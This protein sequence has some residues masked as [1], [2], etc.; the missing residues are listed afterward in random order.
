MFL[1]NDTDFSDGEIFDFLGF[2]A[3]W[4]FIGLL[5][6]R[7]AGSLTVADTLDNRQHLEYLD[8]AG[9]GQISNLN[10]GSI[11]SEAA[12]LKE[13]FVAIGGT[14]DAGGTEDPVLQGI[15]LC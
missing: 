15:D 11:L 12:R 5:D 13:W 8:I 2:S 1:P 4:K 14:R 3:H 6:C 7:L 10:M 9:C